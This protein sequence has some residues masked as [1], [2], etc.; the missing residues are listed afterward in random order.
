M[1]GSVEWVCGGFEGYRSSQPYDLILFQESFQ[2]FDEVEATLRRASELLR[3]GGR[4]VVGDQFLNEDR[5][6]SEAR[7][8]PIDTVL[9]AARHVGF[10]L[11]THCDISGGAARAIDW[12]LERLRCE[13]GE[14]VKR[15]ASRL[16]ELEKDIATMLRSGKLEREAYSSGHL[17][18]RI[19]AFDR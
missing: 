18:Y 1:S 19:L 11:H 10:R 2:Y 4:L 17:S 5:P 16:P 9:R 14:L 13:E 6:R 8:H 3:P 12:M 7:F 15:Y